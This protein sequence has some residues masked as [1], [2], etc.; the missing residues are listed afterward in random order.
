MKKLLFSSI[1]IFFIVSCSKNTDTKCELTSA[2]VAGP[3]KVTSVRY[4]ATPTGTE[5][6]Y[7]NTFYPDVCERDDIITLLANGSAT[8]TD[9]GVKCS[10]PGDDTGTWSLSGNV[11]TID[12]GASNVDNYNCSSITISNTDVFNVGDKMTIVLTR[13]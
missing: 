10:P 4:K 13:Q 1:L 6:D 12:G 5:T 7:Y 11:I 8:Y 9:G 3:Y 2:S